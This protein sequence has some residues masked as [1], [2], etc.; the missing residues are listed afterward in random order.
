MT[1]RIPFNSLEYRQQRDRIFE[2]DKG[3]C[4]SPHCL[5][6][7]PEWYLKGKD[8][9]L[10]HILPISKSEG[11]EDFVNTDANLRVLCPFCHATR[12]DSN[13][14]PTSFNSHA[15]LGLS[16]VLTKRIEATILEKYRWQ[17][18]V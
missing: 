7:M 2:R 3:V 5:D 10:D 15:K 6:K 17:D 9:E 12:D 8:W 4:Q 18:T 11:Y 16:Y 14:E 1:D 13:L